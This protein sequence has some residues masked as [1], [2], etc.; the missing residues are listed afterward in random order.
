MAGRSLAAVNDFAL[1]RAIV[2]PSTCEVEAPGCVETLEPRVM[3]VLVELAD[4]RGR[5]VGRDMLVEQC[6]DGLIVGDDAI[7]RATAR[8]RRLGQDSGAFVL[9]TVRKVGY[10]LSEAEAPAPEGSI[11]DRAEVEPAAPSTRHPVPRR[12]A[13]AAGLVLLAAAAFLAGNRWADRPMAAAGGSIAGAALGRL[14]GRWGMADC[15]PTYDLVV[16][17]GRIVMTAPGERSERRIVAADDVAVLAE[18][19]VPLADH[20]KLFVFRPQ[21]D[22]LAIENRT[23]NDGRVLD[24]C[25]IG[26]R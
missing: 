1:G 16:R 18:G 20:G 12:I 8:L 9:E 5:V 3:R 15:R 13:A 7:N 21:G 11:E 25:P 14:P 19:V 10:R 6:W 26:R 22:R 2:R 4:A 23:S 24:I 17:A